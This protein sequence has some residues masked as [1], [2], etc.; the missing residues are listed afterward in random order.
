MSTSKIKF[1]K[2]AML[3]S[4]LFCFVI[5]VYCAFN[6]PLEKNPKLNSYCGSHVMLMSLLPDQFFSESY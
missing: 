2:T 3:L 1:Y 5:F 4:D 6:I